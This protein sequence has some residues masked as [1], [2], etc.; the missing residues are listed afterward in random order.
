MKRSFESGAQKR[1][2]AK[3]EQKLIKSLPKV[4]S[5]FRTF[6]SECTDPV[7]VPLIPNASDSESHPD[8]Q[9]I[10][11]INSS[12]KL[13]SQV[14]NDPLGE[15][16]DL[17]EPNADAALWDSFGGS[18]NYL[19]E[20]W[21][22][23]GPSR[24][25]NFEC[26]FKNSDRKYEVLQDGKKITEIRKCRSSMFFKELQNGEKVKR[27]WLLYSSSTGRV[28]CFVCKL[29]GSVSMSSNT[30]CVDGFN[31]WKHSA[32]SLSYHENSKEHRK[33]LLVYLKRSKQVGRIDSGLQIQ[34][35]KEKDYWRQVLKR[36]VSVIKFLTER[37][38][39]LRGDVEKFG[40][41]N[42]GNYLGLLELISEYDPFLKE[43]IQKYGAVGSGNVSY[44]SSFTCDEFVEMMGKRVLNQIVKE[45][46]EAKYYSL[47]VDSTPDV[48][49]TDQLTFIIRYVKNSEPIERFL[50]FIP[51]HGHTA[52][53][54]FNEVIGVLNEN[55]ICLSNCRGQAY[56]NA[57]NMSGKYTGLQA[58]I[59]AENPLAEFVPCSSHSL[60]LVGT[61]AAECNIEASKF[62]SFIQSVYK[63]FSAST[64]RWSIL[65]SALTG[66]R[67]KVI[68]PLS[69]TRWSARADA[70]TA[71]KENY[72]SIQ[73][74]LELIMEDND[75]SPDTK[76][77]A[78]S[79][80]KSMGRFETVFLTHLWNDILQRI[81]KVNKVLQK[82]T[83]TLSVAVKVLES[84]KCYIQKK[85]NSFE[86]YE[87][88]TAEII[89]NSCCDDSETRSI[90][91]SSRIKFFDSN[92][93][94]D[95]VLTGR[96]KLRVEIF[97]PI[98][99][100]LVAHLKLRLDAYVRVFNI[101][102]FLEELIT[103]E[104]NQLKIS[105]NAFASRYKNDVCGS[106][107]FE[108]CIHLQCYL[109]EEKIEYSK[110]FNDLK[111][112]DSDDEETYFEN[113]KR[114]ETEDKG[115]VMEEDDIEV[116]EEIEE[117]ENKIEIPEDK[118][119]PERKLNLKMVYRHLTDNGL[120]TAFPNVE[121]CLKIFLSI[122]VSNASAERS[123]SKLK[124][125]KSELRNA[126]KQDRLSNLSLL[127]I[128]N[129]LLKELDFNDVIDDFASKKCRRK[130]L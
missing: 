43:H 3:K 48:S 46:K 95:T 117:P 88:A 78:G 87:K 92:K 127:S 100:T 36:I 72:K 70:V 76:L 50:K 6:S 122:M 35:H 21:M 71:L 81:N 77:T 74:A 60:N 102:G 37:G 7:T 89:G 31:D 123:F 109:T 56:D 67:K 8:N 29:F 119:Y 65:L 20:Y 38:L 23:E 41:S 129:E 104:E 44:L 40:C 32:Q 18:K 103:L 106:E 2:K 130:H 4:T 124:I 15:R 61:A 79:L 125:I 13:S 99:D 54:L 52:E 114:I 17:L 55:D 75:Q 26:D 10:R 120:F 30:F 91:R 112:E 1:Q 101:F 73:S 42:N 47:S 85:R 98:I 57:S 19:Q 96:D 34:I 69:S 22:R 33:C 97:L 108:E 49:H 28:F 115:E 113:E 107:L 9:N 111:H 128:E 121:I 66:R 62:F 83:L 116:D 84:L 94:P 59:S 118:N 24:C 12:T 27:D 80:K 45:V 68:K 53:T 82:P 110:F 14:I 25:Q 16:G 39:P 105:C 63:F 126:M 64:N 51:V 5:F 58:R 93:T 86:T 11:S 90:K